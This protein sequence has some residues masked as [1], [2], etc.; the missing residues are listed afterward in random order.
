METAYLRTATEEDMD[1]LFEWANEAS[2]RANS[3]STS[4]IPYEEHKVWYKKIML[5]TDCRQYIYMYGGQ[6]I[7]QVRVSILGT[8][9]EV[10]Y[11]VCAE[12]RGMGHGKKM[13]Q[14]LYKQMQCDYPQVQ[15]LVA[16][17][18]PGNI[19][20]GKAFFDTGY[21]KKYEVYELDIKR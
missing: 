5:S 19:A 3:F 9:A 7:G 4:M 1:M 13:L 16:K 20:S 11:S 21:I 6:A 2:V 18:K 8:V 12:M 14:L 15:K 10:S 17:V